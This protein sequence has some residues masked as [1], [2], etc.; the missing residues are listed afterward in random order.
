MNV[1]DTGNPPRADRK[2]ELLVTAYVYVSHHPDQAMVWY[3]ALTAHELQTLSTAVGDVLYGV[4]H[5]IAALRGS[6]VETSPRLRDALDLIEPLI[7]IPIDVK[8]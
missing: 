5:I 6:I 1:D 3:A 2:K 4:A 7:D 8:D